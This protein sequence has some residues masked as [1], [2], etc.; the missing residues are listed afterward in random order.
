MYL[1]NSQ[2]HMYIYVYVCYLLS[3]LLVLYIEM[4]LDDRF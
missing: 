2:L 1:V 3:Q 4:K